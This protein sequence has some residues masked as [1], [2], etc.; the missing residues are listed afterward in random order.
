MQRQ[1]QNGRQKIINLDSKCINPRPP[2]PINRNKNPPDNAHRTTSHSITT[3]TTTNYK[4]APPHRRRRQRR[5]ARPLPASP[6]PTGLGGGGFAPQPRTA[7]GLARRA[8]RR[9][10]RG[11]F[12]SRLAIQGVRSNNTEGGRRRRIT[13]DVDNNQRKKIG[14]ENRAGDGTNK[15][16]NFGDAVQSDTVAVVRAVPRASQSQKTKGQS[17]N[18]N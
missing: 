2:D 15:G 10:G 4:G 13:K 16:G 9:G 18:H 14:R 6:H 5:P 11:S 8:R 7:A 12:R 1:R 3:A 17:E